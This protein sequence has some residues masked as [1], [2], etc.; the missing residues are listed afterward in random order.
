MAVKFFLWILFVAISQYAVSS[1]DK[2][3]EYLS[4]LCSHHESYNLSPCVMS[5]THLYQ[6]LLREKPDLIPFLCLL[7][8]VIL[9]D[10]V[11]QFPDIVL[12]VI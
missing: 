6:L 5:P 4:I 8:K 2:W 3:K 1:V 9:W 11:T 10:P 12:N 7:P